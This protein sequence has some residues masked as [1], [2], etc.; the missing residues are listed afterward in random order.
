MMSVCLSYAAAVVN[1]RVLVQH[2]PND[3]VFRT[4]NTKAWII[5]VRHPAHVDEY[6]GDNIISTHAFDP[7]DV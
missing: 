4:L 1:G 3:V 5:K 2:S 7:L 6:I